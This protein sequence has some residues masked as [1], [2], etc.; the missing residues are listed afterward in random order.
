[1]KAIA[2]DWVALEDEEDEEEGEGEEAMR[3]LFEEEGEEED[4]DVESGAEKQ[5]LKFLSFSSGSVLCR[6]RKLLK[7]MCHEGHH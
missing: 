1:M 2:D 7:L 6:E 5:L 3:A 4:T